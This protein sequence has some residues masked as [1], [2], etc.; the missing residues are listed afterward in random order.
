MAAGKQNLVGGGVIVGVH[1]LG[2]H[3]PLLLVHRLAHLGQLVGRR[4]YVGGLHVLPVAGLRIDGQRIELLPLVG[5]ADLHLEGGQLLA[6]ADLRLVGHPLQRVDVLAQC[7]LEVLHQLQ[8]A[9][10]ILFGEVLPDV[11]LAHGHVE[12]AVG[13]G[14]GALPA[15]TGLLLAGHLTAEEVE[16]RSVEI[17]AQIAAGRAQVLG[18]QIAAQLLDREL[19]Q[20]AVYG[21]EHL[22][23]ADDHPVGVLHAQNLEVGIPLHG[24]VAALQIGVAH[25]IVVGA[26]VAQLHARTRSPGNP[27]LHAERSGGGRSGS[28]LLESGQRKDALQEV[29]VTLAQGG[30]LLV[31]IVVAVAHAQTALPDVEGVDIAVHQVGFDTRAEEGGRNARVERSQQLGHVPAFAGEDLL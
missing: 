20:Q 25:R 9:L 22:G 23:L 30:A 10:L 18:G 31:D 6:G 5:I 12:D 3:Q 24:V 19:F 17:V 14:H 16:R 4:P 28:L 26:H 13:G 8:H 1:G 7:G 2:A 11:H 15:G 21:V 29:R 27:L